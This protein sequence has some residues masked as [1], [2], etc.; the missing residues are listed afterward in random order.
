LAFLVVALCTLA[1]SIVITT[2]KPHSNTNGPGLLDYIAHLQFICVSAMLSIAYPHGFVELFSK[3]LSWCLLLAEGWWCLV[4][5]CVSVHLPPSGATGVSRFL[6]MTRI[7]GDGAL[8]ACLIMLSLVLVV[9]GLFSAA[10]LVIKRQLKLY[11][12]SLL[13]CLRHL[14][15]DMAMMPLLL[16]SMN[17]LLANLSLVLPALIVTVVL[18]MWLICGF[19]INENSS[20]SNAI[21]PS[22]MQPRLRFVLNGIVRILTVLIIVSMSACGS[23]AQLSV[24]LAME[25]GLVA[26]V[27]GYRLSADSSRPSLAIK[28]LAGAIYRLLVYIILMCMAV[29]EPGIRLPILATVLLCLHG[30]SLLVYLLAFAMQLLFGINPSRRTATSNSSLRRRLMRPKSLRW[31]FASPLVEID[32]LSLSSSDSSTGAC[33]EQHSTSFTSINIPVNLSDLEYQ[34]L[35]Q[36]NHSK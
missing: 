24:M 29:G 21:F 9:I 18:C 5:N 31:S 15:M 2:I 7:G 35:I 28:Q 19:Y 25:A 3:Q 32:Q 26:T 11:W 4:I 30:M 14:I 16:F 33:R 23:I 36:S 27:I 12:P 13:K 6:N 10:V 34:T 1:I 17:Q 8:Q 20:V 22:Q